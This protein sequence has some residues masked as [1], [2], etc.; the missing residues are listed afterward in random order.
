[1]G[2]KIPL[3]KRPVLGPL[4]YFVSTTFVCAEGYTFGYFYT[5]SIRYAVYCML[6]MEALLLMYLVAC[7]RSAVEGESHDRAS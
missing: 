3:H 7:A 6:F 5:H 1:M 4:V 2:R